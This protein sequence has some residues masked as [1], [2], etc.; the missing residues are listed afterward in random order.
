MKIINNKVS[1]KLIDH[2]NIDVIYQS[3]PDS[4]FD[5]IKPGNTVILKP[6]WVKESHLTNK[7]EW[8]HIITHP[9]IITAVLRK[10]VEKFIA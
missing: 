5:C 2:Y 10:T 3:L 6:N 7:D 8:E 9:S 4:L 1:V